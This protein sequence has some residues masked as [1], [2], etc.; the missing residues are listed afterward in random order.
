MF[1]Y[2]GV[3]WKIIGLLIPE[4]DNQMKL[5][6]HRQTTLKKDKNLYFQ[7]FTDF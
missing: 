7:W 5:D 1:H 6:T 4:N 3:H 2:W